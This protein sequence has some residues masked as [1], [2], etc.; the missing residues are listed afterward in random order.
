MGHIL[1]HRT[2]DPIKEEAESGD[3]KNTI[4]LM[5]RF[6]VSN[7]RHSQAA[8]G[9]RAFISEQRRSPGA[10]MLLVIGER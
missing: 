10:K 9:L 8:M 5:E 6:E 7:S 4:R 3:S 1:S 2:S